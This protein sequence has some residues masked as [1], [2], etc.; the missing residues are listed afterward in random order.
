MAS[1]NETALNTI[2]MLTID[3]L[4]KAGYDS[5]LEIIQQTPIFYALFVNKLNIVPQ[6][7]TW[8]NRDRFILDNPQ[9]S[10]LLY[11][12]LHL[13]GYDYSIEDLKRYCDVDSYTPA[14]P[15]LNPDLGIEATTGLP[16][17]GIANA[18]GIALAQRYYESICK[19][20]NKK[21]ILVDFNTYVF[22]NESDL[23]S[24]ISYEALAFASV[25]KLKKLTIIVE[26]TGMD[27]DG[28]IEATS[29]EDIETRF[30]ALDLDFIY[31]KNGKSIS[32]ITSALK[33]TTKTDMPTV[34]I[35]DNQNIKTN[36]NFKKLS[37]EDIIAL[38]QKYKLPVESFGYDNAT[39]EYISNT[40]INRVNVKYSAWLKEFN[41]VK[42]SRDKDLIDIINLLSKSEFYIDFDSAK[43]QMSDNYC[44]EPYISN[45]KIINLIAPKT[46]YFV[47]GSANQALITNTKIVK[48][49]LMLP[50]NPSGHNIAFGQRNVAMGAILNGLALS[51]LRT[52]GASRLINADELKPSLRLSS[53]MKLPVTY[54]FTHDSVEA[55][56]DGFVFEPIE[57]LTMLRSIP[58]MV[59]FRPADINELIGAWE[60]ILKNKQPVSLVLSNQKLAKLKHTNGKYVQYGAYIVRKE[61]YHLDGIII[62][63][64]SE[65]TSAIKI[66]EEL[67][68]NGIDLRVVS[69][70]S[71]ELFLKQKSIYEEKLL[72]KDVKI[73][74]LEAGSTS[75]WHR[76]ASTKENAIGIDSFGSCG[77]SN[78]VLKFVDFDYNSLLIKIKKM[79]E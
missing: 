29:Y 28:K 8:L 2:K 19:S 35:V 77:K 78:D 9:S 23:Q 34:I 64:G 55:S 52:Y 30:E 21:S 74:T 41:E 59:V 61:K 65:V 42:E 36:D 43:Y 57:Q 11:S 54:I 6:N 26:L 25:Q 67:F 32:E 53:M 63:T 47:G 66:A 3:T 68:T 75:L 15:V 71:M 79:F 1:K 12:L 7:P 76:F 58:D 38:K 18:V 45:G 60:F 10:A 14:H 50:D 56:R 37:N 48:S 33:N 40:M 22:C 73:I 70:P 13:I 5:F 46:K 51:G 16:G 69:M 17:Q 27:N 20:I 72:P 31:I 62:A 49:G 39:K 44:E 24:G 4:K